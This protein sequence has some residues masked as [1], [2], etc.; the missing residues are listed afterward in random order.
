MGVT[1]AAMGCAAVVTLDWPQRRNALGPEEAAILADAVEQ[2]GS[3]ATA[4]VVLTGNGAFCAGGDL[5]TFASLSVRLTQEEIF[6]MVYGTMH[7][8]VGALRT[9]PVPTIAAIDGA[10]VG[11]GMDY[12]LACDIRFVGPNGWIQQG[13]GRVGLVPGAGGVGLLARLN[14]TAL[15]RMVGAQE[16]LGAAEC[17]ALGL[18]EGASS[19]ALDTALQRAESLSTISTEALGHYCT[20]SRRVSW[21]SEAHFEESARIQAGLLGSEEFRQRAERLMHPE[22]SP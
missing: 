17:A 16:R 6:E 1:V 8:V 2:A 10:A 19:T 18:A 9:C 3:Q 7:R 13:W 21:P 12:A 22:G 5:R 11:L 20:L 14:T 15:W 4:A